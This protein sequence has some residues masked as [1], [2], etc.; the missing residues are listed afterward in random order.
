MTLDQIK[1]KCN[2]CM[3]YRFESDSTEKKIELIHLDF[4]CIDV[5]CIINSIDLKQTKV[6]GDNYS[7]R[8][9]DEDNVLA[10][11][12]STLRHRVTEAL[13]RNIFGRNLNN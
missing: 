6:D 5:A 12:R 3:F 13:L 2:A 4:R 11:K 7:S 8:K 10:T 1:V 9:F